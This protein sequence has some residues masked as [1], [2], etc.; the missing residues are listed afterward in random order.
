MDSGDPS[1]LDGQPA[2]RQAVNWMLTGT[3]RRPDEV[4]GTL[5]PRKGTAT[6]EKIAINAVM[7]GARPEYL[8]VIIAAIEGLAD[9]HFDG[10]WWRIPYNGGQG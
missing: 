10:A 4:V 3:K 6:I 1:R 7:A 8:P 9:P 5:P 2:R